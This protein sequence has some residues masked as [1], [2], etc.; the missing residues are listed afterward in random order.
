[1]SVCTF[2]RYKKLPENRY[3]FPY[4]TSWIYGWR[5]KDN[6]PYSSPEYGC[7]SVIHE[8]FYR[9][10]ASSLQRDPEW[11]KMPQTNDA[12]NFNEILTY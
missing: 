8:S 12:K 11:Y 9:R 5:Q 2:Y 1:M 10:N 3:F 6:L 4:C 7:R